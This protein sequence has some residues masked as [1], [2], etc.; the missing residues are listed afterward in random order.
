MQHINYQGPLVSDH[1]RDL[2][3]VQ[4]LYESGSNQIKNET[5]VEQTRQ[6][7]PVL[8]FRGHNSVMHDE[9]RSITKAHHDRKVVR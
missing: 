2:P 4:V 6:N 7:I 9:N 8:H 1:F 3:M 5:S